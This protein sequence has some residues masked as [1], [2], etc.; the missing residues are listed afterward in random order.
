MSS[1]AVHTHRLFVTRLLNSL[2]TVAPQSEHATAAEENPLG[3]V[4][5]AVKKQMLVLQVLFPNELV[6][7]LDLLDRHLVTRYR[8]C[9]SQL[10]SHANE[11]QRDAGP[12]QMQGTSET[13]HSPDAPMREAETLDGLSTD[14]PSN[15]CEA[16]NQALDTSTDG[17]QPSAVQDTTYTTSIVYYVRSAQQRSSRFSTSYDTTTCYEVRLQA[18]NCSCP[19]FAFAAFPATNNEA[20]VPLCDAPNKV[21]ESELIEE[22]KD[23]SWVFGGLGL[24]GDMPPV[25]KHLLACVLAERCNGLFGGFVK[26][27]N[28]DVEVAAGWAAGWGD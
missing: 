18:W 20:P 14:E 10:K 27:Q 2:S 26:E 6:P 7:A 21:D 12:V 19:A 5:D 25:C 28:V 11:A 23:S 24:C 4:S 8:I 16:A 15:N 1:P 13:T 3:S 17:E 9:D 22:A